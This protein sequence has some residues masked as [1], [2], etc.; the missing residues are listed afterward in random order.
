MKLINIS[1]NVSINPEMIISVE[2]KKIKGEDRM[3]VNLSDR[4]YVV[5]IP[6][7]TFLTYLTEAGV[8]MGEQFYSV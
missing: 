5:E 3:I 8:S 4:T 1:K 7:M 2:I 6:E